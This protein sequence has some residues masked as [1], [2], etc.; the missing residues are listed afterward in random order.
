MASTD[1]VQMDFPAL[2][3]KGQW[4]SFIGDPSPG[5]TAMISGP[6]KYGKSILA[7]SFAGYL[8]RNHGTVLYVAR[9]EGIDRTLRDKLEEVA[10]PQLLVSEN[11]PGNLSEY[12]FIF[13]DSVTKLRLTPAD[14]ES[15]QSRYPGKSFSFIFQ[16]TKAGQARGTRTFEHD[17][18]IVISFPEK[19]FAVQNG[20]FN[21]GGD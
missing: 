13:L 3:F 11:I 10:H 5:F 19:G 18:D 16:S 14:L 7:V 15:L 12:Q 21:Q 17:M 1:I 6:P 20:R 8:A 2:G 4:L 9:E